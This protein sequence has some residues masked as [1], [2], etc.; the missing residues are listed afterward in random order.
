MIIAHIKINYYIVFVE[1]IPGSGDETSDQ[2]LK[3][4]SPD[5][6]IKGPLYTDGTPV[7]PLAISDNNIIFDINSLESSGTLRAV[8]NLTAL[9]VSLI[10]V[11]LLTFM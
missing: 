1:F 9:L 6:R 2:D 7:T 4:V 10:A 5:S 11:S 8:V 3:P